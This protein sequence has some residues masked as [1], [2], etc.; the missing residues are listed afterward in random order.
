MDSEPSKV[1]SWLKQAEDALQKAS[2][3]VSEAWM[4]TE[5]TRREAWLTAQRAAAQASEA[6]DQGIDAA[7]GAWER[8]ATDEPEADEDA[9]TLT[10]VV[11]EVPDEPA[12]PSDTPDDNP[13]PPT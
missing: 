6:L 4:A 2:E 3:A 5:G 10:V 11:D 7:K 12:P 9:T 13:E 8:A 1:D